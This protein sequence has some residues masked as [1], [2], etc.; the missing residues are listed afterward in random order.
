MIKKIFLITMFLQSFVSYSL[1]QELE[2]SQVQDNGTGPDGV[3]IFPKGMAIRCGIT[4]HDGKNSE[5]IKEC[6]DR[7][8]YLTQDGVTGKESSFEIMSEILGQM[9]KEYIKTA[10]QNKSEA[11]DYE[12][13]I[14]EEIK[15]SQA[16]TIRDKQEQM[17]NLSAM[18]GRNIIN[19]NQVYASLLFLQAMNSFY[20]YDF[21]N[22]EINIQE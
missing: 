5:K 7:L 6:L 4:S 10:L 2:I 12:D 20:E 21:S 11:G 22:R 8:V 16:S 17:V 15:N 18:G 14:E 3:M 19:L 13:K 9:N 1:S